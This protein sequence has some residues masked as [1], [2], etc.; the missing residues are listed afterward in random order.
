LVRGCSANWPP[1]PLSLRSFFGSIETCRTPA[2]SANLGR[3]FPRPAERRRS[4]R[5][6]GSMG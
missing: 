1:A 2:K 4:P 5:H 3:A 6:P